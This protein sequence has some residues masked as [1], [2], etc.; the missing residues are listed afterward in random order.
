MRP[1]AHRGGAYAPVGRWNAEWGSK[2]AS[3]ERGEGLRPVADRGALRLRL[4]VKEQ[5]EKLGS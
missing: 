1:P 5:K 4:E 2:A 3:I